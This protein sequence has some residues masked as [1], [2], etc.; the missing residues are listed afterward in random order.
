M[1][2]FQVGS[3]STATDVEA[4]LIDGA[5]YFI[6]PNEPF[7]IIENHVHVGGETTA[8]RETD[9]GVGIPLIDRNQPL[10]AVEHYRQPLCTPTIKAIAAFS[11]LGGVFLA[12]FALLLYFMQDDC[13]SDDHD[14]CR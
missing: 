10:Q 13:Q 12:G 11:L 7:K 1:L 6:D 5:A 3:D 8:D 9:Q 4:N 14:P 2:K